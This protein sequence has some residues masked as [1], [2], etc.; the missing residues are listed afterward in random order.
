MLAVAVD[1]EEETLIS[2]AWQVVEPFTKLGAQEQEYVDQINNGVARPEL[3]FRNDPV[4]SARIAGHPAILWKV[5]N[6]RK[7]HR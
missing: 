2:C 3:L 1:P 6:V 5:N 4:L 7:K